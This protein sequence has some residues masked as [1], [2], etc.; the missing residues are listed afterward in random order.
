MYLYVI[1]GSMKIYE[2]GG[3]VRDSLLGKTP[4]DFDYVVI[5]SS[6]EEMKENGFIQ[7]GKI[8]LSL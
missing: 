4:N 8:F 6:I 3:C 7:V 5:G 1:G 2:V